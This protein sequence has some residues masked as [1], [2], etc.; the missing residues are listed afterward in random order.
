MTIKAATYTLARFAVDGPMLPPISNTLPLAE[1]VR[2]AL[3][4]ICTRIVLRDNPGLA[5]SDIW[6]LS[7]AFWGKDDQG[8]PLT[9]HGHAFF[10]PADEDGDGWLDHVTVIAPMGFNSLECQAIDRLRLLRFGDGDPL[11]L[12]LIGLGNAHDFRAPLLAQSAVWVSA[13]PFV[14]TRFPKLRGSK[15]DRPTDYATPTVFAG[16]VLR[17]E[18]A[19]RSDLP[20]IVSI[21]D[22]EVIGPRGLRAIQFKRSRSRPG[23]DGGRRPTGAFRVTFAGPVHGPLCL[24]HSCHFGLGVFVPASPGAPRDE[25]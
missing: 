22:E 8:R 3:L 20:S 5:N 23:D 9:G 10:L 15:R 12:V 21:E 25:R 24:G 13:T 18:L 4:C 14:V 7:P 11:Q 6:R 16:H 19:R 1:Q 2:R 17:Q